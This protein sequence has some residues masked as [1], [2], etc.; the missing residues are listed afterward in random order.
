[1][2]QWSP[3]ADNDE[4]RSAADVSETL[5]GKRRESS[6][7]LLSKESRRGEL[8]HTRSGRSP[9]RSR[10]PCEDRGLRGVEQRR[11]VISE[12]GALTGSSLTATFISRHGDSYGRELSKHLAADDQ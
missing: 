7:L 4:V 6:N 9:R 10:Q 8:G 2:S 12:E 1:V 5:R 3:G 11:V